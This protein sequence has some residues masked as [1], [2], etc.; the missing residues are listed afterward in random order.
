MR[1][2]ALLPT[3][4][5]RGPDFDERLRE[6]FDVDAAVAEENA[7][8]KNL[9]NARLALPAKD[10][11]KKDDDLISK[12]NLVARAVEV[13]EPPLFGIDIN[14]EYAIEEHFR[15][16]LPSAKRI[17]V[18]EMYKILAFNNMDPEIYTI[19]FWSEYFKISPATIRN[20]VNYVAYPIFNQKTKK[21]ESVLY[22]QDTELVEQ[23]KH[24]ENK[25][26]ISRED[27]LGYLEADYYDRVVKEH[28]DEKGLFGKVEAPSWHNPAA[29]QLE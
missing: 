27:Y 29:A 5:H 9:A 15:H 14:E 23:F 12:M 16:D 6:V 21:L 3:P 26:D 1:D 11:T 20:I 22:F 18:G 19:T 13:D 10:L 25:N 24:L 28:A 7:M 2:T 4:V 17:L 8:L